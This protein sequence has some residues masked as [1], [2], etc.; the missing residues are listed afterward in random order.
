VPYSRGPNQFGEIERADRRRS[1]AR[2]DGHGRLCVQLRSLPYL[3]SVI[4]DVDI[5][6]IRVLAQLDKWLF[7]F[8]WGAA[9]SDGGGSGG[10][11]GP[12]AAAGVEEDA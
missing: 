3:Q 7:S 11:F 12:V 6:S 1:Q 5:D 4:G 10:E 2:P 9:G 8:E